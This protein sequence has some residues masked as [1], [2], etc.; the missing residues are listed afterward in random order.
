M[1]FV[2]TTDGTVQIKMQSYIDDIIS[3]YM[4]SDSLRQGAATPALANLFDIDPESEILGNNDK[5]KFHSLVARLLYLAKR[6]RPDILT[7]IAFLA[8]RVTKPTAEDNVKL[9]RVVRYLR[10]TRDLHLTLSADNGLGVVAYIDASYGPHA[11]GK[12]HSGSMIT[13]GRGAVYVRSAK[14]RLVTESS[15]EAELVALSDEASQVIWLRD[16]LIH[17]G[18]E[19]K[20]ATVYQDNT[21][22]VAMTN[23][24]RSTSDRTRHVAIRYF[25]V[26]DRVDAGEVD[27]EYLCTKEMIADINTKPLQG[28]LFNKFRD[29]LLG[30]RAIVV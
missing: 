10:R 2:F 15:A 22:A 7:P 5:E 14:Q 1:T 28:A 27:L 19:I 23:K 24:G 30:I 12:S 4:D 26:K 9:S 20:A 17:Q 18:H 21:A 6:V 13:L 29:E 25:W 3:N 8:T 16:F 11:D